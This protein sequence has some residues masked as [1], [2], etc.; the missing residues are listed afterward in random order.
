[1]EVSTT[2]PSRP[3]AA[4]MSP[5]RF[6]FRQPAKKAIVDRRIRRNNWTG[7]AKAELCSRHFSRDQFVSGFEPKTTLKDRL[8]GRCDDVVGRPTFLALNEEQAIVTYAKISRY[9]ED[10]PLHDLVPPTRSGA[11][12]R[13]LRNSGTISLPKARTKRLNNSFL[14]CAVDQQ[15]AGEIDLCHPRHGVQSKKAHRKPQCDVPPP[16]E[17]ETATMEKAW[18]HNA[19]LRES[20]ARNPGNLIPLPKFETLPYVL[21]VVEGILPVTV[22]RAQRQMGSSDC[23]LF[24]IY[25]QDAPMIQ[26][27]QCANWFHY[28]CVNIS[29]QDV[30]V[31]GRREGVGTPWHSAA[32][33]LRVP[34]FPRS[35][36]I[37]R[38]AK[39]VSNMSTHSVT[40][41]N[42]IPERGIW[43]KIGGDHGGGSFKMTYKLLN[44]EHPN[45]KH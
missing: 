23:G 3:L 9:L 21:T 35:T 13:S 8:K 29:A 34:H 19:W 5:L 18:K 15:R 25:R 4:Q 27:D 6:W 33:A 1:M 31:L 17:E 16:S 28:R 38:D 12:G 7:G 36:T 24:A 20:H 30:A 22:I 44:K 41:Q 45:S 14:H 40:W 43:I 32:P 39:K 26:C 11:T 42:A 2:A 10:H 37:C